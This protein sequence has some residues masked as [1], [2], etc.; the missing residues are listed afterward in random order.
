MA[1]ESFILHVVTE[2]RHGDNIH[3]I[4]VN[5]PP[6]RLTVVVKVVDQLKLAHKNGNAYRLLEQLGDQ[7][8]Q[9]VVDLEVIPG[10]FPYK[11]RGYDL[12]IINSI[13]GYYNKHLKAE[14][15]VKEL[16]AL[17]A[18]WCAGYARYKALAD[19]LNKEDE[20]AD[21]KRSAEIER[22]ME[23]NTEHMEQL[24]KRCEAVGYDP[25][26]WYFKD[27]KIPPLVLPVKK[28]LPPSQRY[29]MPKEVSQAPGF[30][31]PL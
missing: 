16:I 13:T 1:A 11:T 15:D 6:E 12:D 22:E 23:S 8:R 14:D 18:K 26:S 25:G 17:H 29:E 24:A 7:G 19:H 2:S 3:D 10:Y 31:K 9:R 27:Y 30:D 28:E 4:F 5:I 20:T 21:S